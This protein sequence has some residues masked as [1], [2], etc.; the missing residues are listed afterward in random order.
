M[1]LWLL[2]GSMLGTSDSNSGTTQIGLLAYLNLQHTKTV[3]QWLTQP[4]FNFSAFIL[5]LGL[6]CLIILSLSFLLARL[7]AISD[8]R[9]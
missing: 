1:S 9:R 4:E 6:S 3:E 2:W 7:A 8:R 5:T